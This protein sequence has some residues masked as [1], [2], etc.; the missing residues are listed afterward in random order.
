[1]FPDI[2]SCSALDPHLPAIRR[3]R[4][5]RRTALENDLRTQRIPSMQ[6]DRIGLRKFAQ[7]HPNWARLADAVHQRPRWT[8]LIVRTARSDQ[9]ATALTG[10]L[11]TSPISFTRCHLASR[12]S[13]S[14]RSFSR[15]VLI[16]HLLSSRKMT[17]MARARSFPIFLIRMDSLA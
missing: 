3:A 12:R 15:S 11:T 6:K 14:A 10:S 8:D 5:H 17:V 13:Q 7:E 9:A 1:M 4:A 2:G 16:L